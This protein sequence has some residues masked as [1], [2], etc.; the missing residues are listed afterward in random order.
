MKRTLVILFHALVGWGLCGA[1]MGIG[2]KLWG[3][4][5]A[6]V[7]HAVAAPVIFVVLSWIYFKKF[8]YTRPMPTAGIFTAVIVAM[9]AGLVAPFFEK[10]YAMFASIPGTWI[11]FALIFIATWVTGKYVMRND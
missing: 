2:R 5:T 9:D 4:E 10:S 3:I 8:H 7:V 1:V 11:P 6:L